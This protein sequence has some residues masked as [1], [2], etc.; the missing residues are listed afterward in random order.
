MKLTSKIHEFC[1]VHRN[2]KRPVEQTLKSELLSLAYSS[3]V[4]D[5]NPEQFKRAVDALHARQCSVNT[6]SESMDNCIR[7]DSDY[8]KNCRK[9]VETHLQDR[10]AYFGVDQCESLPDINK[11]VLEGRDTFLVIKFMDEQPHIRATLEC[12]LNQDDIDPGRL[13]IVATDNM[14]KDSS[15]DIVREMIAS[16]TTKIRI[17]LLQQPV[18]GGG[19]AARYGVDH[20]LA[21]IYKMCENDGD[22]SRLHH[23]RVAVSDGDTVYHPRLLADGAKTLDE[24]PEIDGIMP[25][26]MYK[27]TSCHRFFKQYVPRDPTK[28]RPLWRQTRSNPVVFPGRLATLEDTQVLP[29]K[30]RKRVVLADCEGMLL[31]TRAD[32]GISQSFFVPFVATLESDLKFGVIEDPDGRIAYIF[33]DGI[34]TLEAAPVSGL[35]T[36]LRFLECGGVQTTEKWKW[37]TLI[38]HDLF[39]LWAFQHMGL[40]ESLILPDTSDAL[41]MFRAWAFSV[42]GQHQLSKP[43]LKRVTGT[44]Y[45]SGR[46][47]QSFGGQ[48]VLGSSH[49]YSE[50]EVDRLAKMIRNFA[51]DQSVF[52]GNTRSRGV[53]RA[54]GLY[55]HM[56]GIQ[57]QVEREV[58]NYDDLFY[59]NIAFPER[60]IFPVRWM[61]QNFIGYY[62]C[63]DKKDR[64]IVEKQSLE[65]IFGN[66]VWNNIKQSFFQNSIF[67]ELS[68]LP[69]ERFR[70]RCEEIAEA[71]MIAHWGEI[72]S[73]YKNTIDS[74]FRHNDLSEEHYAFLL[75][76]IA[77]CRNAL[78]EERPLIDEA[79]VWSAQDFVID[80]K[81]GQ[82]SSIIPERA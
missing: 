22:W 69:F 81:R 24:N 60:L 38:G 54:S 13:V 35:E 65:V 79:L 43:G 19:S 2:S 41:K 20:C 56:T 37:H 51:N 18:S 72:M 49:A 44:D 25:F 82:V 59:Q 66:H 58:R 14:S 36:S 1:P 75:D 7:L 57:D 11:M 16:N 33:S 46:V 52:Y 63:A 8:I 73:F 34:I 55:L 74:F 53:E 80:E 4:N 64:P 31:K 76:D 77:S 47:I 32:G 67:Q 5:P 70:D 78:L 3:D 9:I 29:R 28:L 50:T 6:N 10:K 23:A 15:K 12:L 71:I 39:L 27:S 30:L 40:S 48:T 45:Q 26:L 17:Y 61:L 42:G 68:T 21:T 62:S